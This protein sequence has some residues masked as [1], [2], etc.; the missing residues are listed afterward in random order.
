MKANT[1][2]MQVVS[3]VS[4]SVNWKLCAAIGLVLGVALAPQVGNA[5]TYTWNGGDNVDSSWTSNNNW[6]GTAAVSGTATIGLVSNGKGKSGLG[7]TTQASQAINVSGDVYRLA[8]GSTTGTVSFGATHVGDSVSQTLTVRN[9]A[10]TDGYSEKLDAGF[11]TATGDISTSGVASLIAAGSN[12]NAMSVGID[13]TNA[14]AKSGNVDVNFSFDGTRTSSLA[15]ISNG[16]QNV[17]V[18]GDVYNYASIGLQHVSGGN[19]WDSSRLALDFGAFNQGNGTQTSIFSLFN[20]GLDSIY[21]DLIDGN[22]T[23]SLGSA[24]SRNNVSNFT[25]LAGGSSLTNN[26]SFLFDTSCVGN[27]VSSVFLAFTG[28]NASHYSG[29]L[30]GMTINFKSNVSAVSMPTAVWLFLTGM[31]AVIIIME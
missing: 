16:S 15:T 7:N 24:F 11:G 12:S 6:S 5:K 17:S 27:Y 19:A 8:S 23:F 20:S 14:D 29:A 28:H 21:T 4:Q 1:N 2:E 10:P 13:T 31:T 30:D 3:T 25:N 9:A 22:N 18:S 26:L